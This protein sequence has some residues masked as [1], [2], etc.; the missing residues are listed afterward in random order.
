MNSR[1]MDTRRQ[2]R[3]NPSMFSAK[4]L[5][6]LP[7]YGPPALSFPEA[8]AFREGYVVEF[9][10]EHG[11]SWVGNFACFDGFGISSVHSELG[12]NAIVVV[13]GGTGYIVDAES[14]ALV[15]ELG[16]DIKHIWFD[17]RTRAM[18]IGNGLWFE[19]FS[20]NKIFWQSRRL[21]WDG[22]RILGM[23]ESTVTSRPSGSCT[24]VISICLSSIFI[25]NLL[26]DLGVDGH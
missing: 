22:V 7:A 8:N 24:R 19:S 13:A 20:A 21:S 6:G 12:A 25:F 23:N 10:S 11:E 1:I 17:E 9:T 2:S 14:K 5:P 26:I 4:P 18:I 15:R 16:F 3:Y